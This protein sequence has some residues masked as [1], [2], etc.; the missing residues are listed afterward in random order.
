MD[1]RRVRVEV[2]RQLLDVVVA[3][4][5]QPKSLHLAHLDRHAL[6]VVVMR[7]QRHEPFHATDGP[8]VGDLVVLHAQVDEVAVAQLIGQFTHHTAVALTED[9]HLQV[10][11]VAHGLREDGEIVVGQRQIGERHHLADFIR[12]ILDAVI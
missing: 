2:D 10:R 6:D 5:E 12:D 7:P 9:Q 1:E 3:E 11:Y 4:L 8:Q